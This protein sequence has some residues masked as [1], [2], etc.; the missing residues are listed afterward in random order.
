MMGTSAFDIA[1]QILPNWEIETT[2]NLPLH[3]HRCHDCM[4]FIEHVKQN[5]QGGALSIYLEHQRKHWRRTLCD[6]M[7]DKLSEKYKDGLE[8]G[9]RNIE[10]LEDKLD[11]F[12]QRVQ[13]LEA[14]NDELG[15]KISELSCANDD[16]RE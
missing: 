8:E 7:R 15:R 13:S 14:E 5:L 4:L 6:E 9:E 16:L 3:L 2:M 11:Y 10:T 1:A 12:H